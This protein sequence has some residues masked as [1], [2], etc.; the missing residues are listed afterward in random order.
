MW[1]ICELKIIYTNTVYH[2]MVIYNI[3]K[4]VWHKEKFGIKK[5]LAQRK[6]FGTKEKVWHKEKKITGGLRP[7]VPKNKKVY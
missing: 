2:I 7:L 6:K 1:I 4:K 3:Y 5:S